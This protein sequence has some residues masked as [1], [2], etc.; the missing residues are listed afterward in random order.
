[1]YGGGP[2]SQAVGDRLSAAGVPL[3]S[4][5][6]TTEFTV[7]NTFLPDMSKHPTWEYSKILVHAEVEMIPQEDSDDLFDGSLVQQMSKSSVD[8]F[9]AG[10]SLTP[11]VINTTIN[12]RPGYATERPVPEACHIAG[13]LQGVWPCGRPD[14]VVNGREEAIFVADPHIQAALIFGRGRFQNGV[15][16]QPTEPFD[17]NDEEK[18]AAFRLNKI[19]PTVEKVNAFAL[20]HSRVFKE[21]T[22]KGTIHHQ[23]CINTYADEVEAVYKQP[24]QS[25]L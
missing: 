9:Q 12:E 22:V 6:G 19:W 8:S 3:L 7:M 21:L 5:Y 4:V 20:S 14:Y 2:L 11:F 10:H 18:L 25:C 1:M 17:P 24:I 15:L 23:I 16:I 13:V